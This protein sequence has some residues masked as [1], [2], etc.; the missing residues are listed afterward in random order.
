MIAIM[1]LKEEIFEQNST[2]FHVLDENEVTE[3]GKF[4]AQLTSL[5]KEVGANKLQL[6]G[7]A[8]VVDQNQARTEQQFVQQNTLVQGLRVDVDR[9]EASLSSLDEAV[10]NVQGD[11]DDLEERVESTVD[12][13]NTR[14]DHVNSLLSEVK[15]DVNSLKE[16]TSEL[17]MTIAQLTTKVD[18]M[19]AK[20]DGLQAGLTNVVNELVVTQENVSTLEKVT[21]T[22]DRA[23]KGKHKLYFL[24]EYGRGCWTEVQVDDPWLI[25]GV[26]YQGTFTDTSYPGSEGW[27]SGNYDFMFYITSNQSGPPSGTAPVCSGQWMYWKIATR[28]GAFDS[29]IAGKVFM[30][31]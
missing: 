7:L 10:E 8:K 3:I 13:I 15:S 6:D 22:G 14:I 27:L 28:G 2:L 4:S 31:T 25:Y 1:S 29:S 5:E 24:D 12:D 16:T 20:I 21:L 23:L 17:K 19:Q 18:T 9:V 11:V 30:Y 26:R